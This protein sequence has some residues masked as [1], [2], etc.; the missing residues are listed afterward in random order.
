MSSPLIE[1]LQVYR[2][3]TQK[4]YL[5]QVARL[6]SPDEWHAFSSSALSQI[7]QCLSCPYVAV[8]DRQTDVAQKKS[9][10]VIVVL[11]FLIYDAKSE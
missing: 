8:P 11:L 2:D 10:I 7:Y 5:G 6:H 1:P 3:K 4:I 9:C